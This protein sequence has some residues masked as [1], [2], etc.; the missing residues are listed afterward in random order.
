MSLLDEAGRLG[1]SHTPEELRD[2]LASAPAAKTPAAS[3]ARFSCPRFDQRAF[4]VSHYAGDVT[5]STDNLLEKNGDAAAR[6]HVVLLDGSGDSFVRALV[7]EAEGAEARGGAEGGKKGGGKGTS[8]CARFRGQLGELMEVLKGMQPHYVRCI[9]P[10]EGGEAGAFEAVRVLQQLRCGGVLEAVRISCAGYPS[11]MTL[12]EFAGRFW[13]ID[14]AMARS[15]APPRDMARALLERCGISDFQIGRSKVFMRAGDRARMERERA[16]ALDGAARTVQTRVRAHQ[17]MAAARA[18]FLRARQAALTLQ[19]FARGWAARRAATAIRR[20]M[21]ATQLQAATRG[22]IAR[23]A[24]SRART[25]ATTIQ[26]AFRGSVAR[27][28]YRTAVAAAREARRKEEAV[29]AL[30]CAV[31]G[32]LA[33]RV[34]RR[35]KAEAREAS[36]LLADKSNLERTLSLREQTLREVVEQ[37][38]DL[39]RR[40]REEAAKREEAAR[41]HEEELARARNEA[42]A[43]ARAAEEHAREREEAAE[44]ALRRVRLLEE[45]LERERAGGKETK[46]ARA[47]AEVA[48]EELKKKYVEIK[49]RMSESWGPLLMRRAVGHRS[50]ASVTP[51]VDPAVLLLTL[52]VWPLLP[53]P[54]CRILAAVSLLSCV[55]RLPCPD[56]RV[57]AITPGM[58]CHIRQPPTPQS[59]T[60]T[61]ATRSSRSFV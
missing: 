18:A 38:D 59:S 7:T 52:C 35:L 54:C 28:A 13:H 42:E 2:R 51:G 15:G 16:V 23:R 40:L 50:A 22:W 31:R 49:E 33:R 20:E 58:R 30:Q 46:E 19:R 3:A 6:E 56:R 24:L 48:L 53:C 34:L 21:R 39:K 44:A 17:A 4:T 12:E 26:A 45:E 29:T 32:L 10:S 57:V 47:E 9:K 27:A 1:G 25:A 14:V 43:A 37:R 55:S 60:G 36:R 41:A 11:R 61:S 8:V 5:Y